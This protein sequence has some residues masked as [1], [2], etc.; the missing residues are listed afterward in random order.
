MNFHLLVFTKKHLFLFV[1]FIGINQLIL[2]QTVTEDLD[3]Q[4]IS[5]WVK[6]YP[7]PIIEKEY[8][9]LNY[10]RVHDESQYNHVEKVS[11]HRLFYY[12]KTKKGINELK[13]FNISYD[14]EYTEID[15]HKIEIHRG[16][17]QISLENNLHREVV[18]RTEFLG[19]NLY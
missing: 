5:E 7:K 2:G 1:L 14:P 10:V 3:F 17:E 13:S 16:K 12:I 8:S 11:Y 19:Q 9:N 18:K 4:P 6:N 15:I